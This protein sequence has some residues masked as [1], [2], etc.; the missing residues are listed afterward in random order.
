M[1]VT[2]LTMM[3]LLLGAGSP[4]ETVVRTYLV[5]FWNSTREK[6]WVFS[7]N[8]ERRKLRR[9]PLCSSSQTRSKQHTQLHT[10]TWDPAIMVEDLLWPWPW[11]HHLNFYESSSKIKKEE[12][13]ESWGAE[14]EQISH[15]AWYTRSLHLYCNC[16]LLLEGVEGGHGEGGHEDEVALAGRPSQWWKS[17]TQVMELLRKLCRCIFSL[18]VW[19]A[20]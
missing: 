11:Q 3:K 13:A 15:R 6:V 9:S 2:R 5:S 19:P 12:N 4:I 18:Q 16:N 7:S 10:D 20:L 8:K 17:L 1:D 14:L